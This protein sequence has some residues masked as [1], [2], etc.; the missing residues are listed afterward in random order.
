MG[1]VAKSEVQW[2][3]A[4]VFDHCRAAFDALE[5]IFKPG[6]LYYLQAYSFEDI[7]GD[8]PELTQAASLINGSFI[9]LRFGNSDFFGPEGPTDW[10]IGSIF[11]EGLHLSGSY[12]G[13][14]P[15]FTE[16]SRHCTGG[17]WILTV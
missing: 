12:H 14:M 17:S 15:G 11:H 2:G 3:T 6:G 16:T 1:R 4:D 8:N 9:S 10:G 5:Q 13:D 7:A